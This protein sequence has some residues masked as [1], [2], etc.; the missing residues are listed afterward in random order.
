MGQTAS[1]ATSVVAAINNKGVEAPVKTVKCNCADP[2]CTTYGLNV[3]HFFQGGGFEELFANRVANAVNL[4]MPFVVALAQVP[5]PRADFAGDT[6]DF[7]SENYGQARCL[8]CALLHLIATHQDSVIPPH[9]I[10]DL[11]SATE[12]AREA[13]VALEST[14]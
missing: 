4:F 10:V 13:I 5:C 14:R 7:W 11:W 12:I 3:G 1:G 6:C 8:R 2:V 9:L